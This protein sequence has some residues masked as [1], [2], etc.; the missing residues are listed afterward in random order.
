MKGKVA[1]ITASATGIGQGIAERLAKEGASVIVSSRNQEHI[2][3]VV[4]LIQDRGHEA[5]GVVCD[6]SR[7]D[8]LDRLVE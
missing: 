6:V 8:H 4:K 2:D 1:V 7:K 5:H 3:H